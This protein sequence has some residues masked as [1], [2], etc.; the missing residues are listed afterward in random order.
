MLQEEIAKNF[1]R[2]RDVEKELAELQLQLHMNVQPKRQGLEL[3]RR[4]IEAQAVKVVAAERANDIAQREA[5]HTA[6]ELAAELQE[7]EKLSQELI[8]LV[9]QSANSQ[10]DKLAELTE[11]LKHLN[12]GLALADHEIAPTQVPAGAAAGGQVQADGDGGAAVGVKQEAVDPKAEAARKEAAEA[13]AAAAARARHVQIPGRSQRP[14]TPVH[15]Q[16]QPAVPAR[17]ARDAQGTFR[18]FE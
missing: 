4:K 14:R 8:M 15:A 13:E 2:V 3:L 11:R 16:R 7:K 12:T 17:E 9:S 10:Y 5:A 1:N 6:E 18:G